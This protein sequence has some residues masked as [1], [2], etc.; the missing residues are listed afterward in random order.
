MAGMSGP[1]IFTCPVGSVRESRGMVCFNP[2]SAE[3]MTRHESHPGRY[4]IDKHR[5][6][7][8]REGA[9]DA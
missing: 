3:E 4:L 6:G 9:E 1:C 8:R 5:Y 7:R 2:V